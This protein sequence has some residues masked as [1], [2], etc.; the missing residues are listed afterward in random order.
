MNDAGTGTVRSL[1]AW[2]SE[3]PELSERDILAVLKCIGDE[4]TGRAMLRAIRHVRHAKAQGYC[5][6]LVAQDF[7]PLTPAHILRLR[8][9]TLASDE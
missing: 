6:G 8:V 4:L 2:C 5:A 9:I 1:S 3:Y 7:P